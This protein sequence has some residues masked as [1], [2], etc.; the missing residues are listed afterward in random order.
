MSMIFLPA[1]IVYLKKIFYS[2]YFEMDN[3]AILFIHKLCALSM[4]VRTRSASRCRPCTEWVVRRYWTARVDSDTDNITRTTP[5]TNG[6]TAAILIS[7]AITVTQS[8]TRVCRS[9]SIVQ[10]RSIVRRL[11]PSYTWT[12]AN[13]SYHVF[14][15]CVLIMCFF[16]GRTS[17]TRYMYV[18]FPYIN[19]NNI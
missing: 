10:S 18:E 17:I 7:T 16:I 13:V 9:R 2:Q 14:L 11:P 3:K 1:T 6:W 5:T 15:S 19:N 4:Q 12:V 8:S